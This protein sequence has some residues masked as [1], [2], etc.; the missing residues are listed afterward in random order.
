MLTQLSVLLFVAVAGLTSNAQAATSKMERPLIYKLH[1]EG[2]H[3]ADGAGHEGFVPSF[4]G[5]IGAFTHSPEGRKFIIQVPGV[6]QSELSNGEIADLMNWLLV[7]YDPDGLANDFTPYNEKEVEGWRNNPISDT[8]QL[9]RAILRDVLLGEH[10]LLLASADN[11]SINMPASPPNSFALCG[12]CHTTSNDSAH[13]MGPNLRGV[14]GRKAGTQKG[15]SFSGAMKDSG[16]TW[17]AE[18]L[19]RFLESP[20]EVVPN[21]SMMYFGEADPAKRKEIINYLTQLR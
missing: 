11:T 9:R 6:S 5:Q 1:C 20:R 13:G 17:S 15:F 12:A 3:M 19:N 8:A 21:S 14:I 2:C 10:K 4:V 7:A 16:I 18:E